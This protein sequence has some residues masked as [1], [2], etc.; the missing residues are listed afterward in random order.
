LVLVFGAEEDFLHT[1][2][3]CIEPS[4]RWRVRKTALRRSAASI[5]KGNMAILVTA[6][7][8]AILTWLFAEITHRHSDKRAMAGQTSL[9]HK[10]EQVKILT[11]LQDVVL[12][13]YSA[14]SAYLWGAW[15]ESERSLSKKEQACLGELWE[16][17]E[18]L[19]LKMFALSAR[20]D[21]L[22]IR[23]RID[24][25]EEVA[26]WRT[27]SPGVHTED[28]VVTTS[29]D[30]IL[31]DDHYVQRIAIEVNRMMGD[32]QLELLGSHNPEY[33]LPAKS[34]GS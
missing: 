31:S 29:S 4:F 8:S 23:S 2:S 6:V 10:T 3:Y 18:A 33:P 34:D 22:R 7:V 13:Y 9:L 5:T 11:E 24:F 17:M 1:L 15:E 19:A 12:E 26:R 20:V 32:Y 30:N 28:G 14:Y 25:L 21:H 16:N 27:V